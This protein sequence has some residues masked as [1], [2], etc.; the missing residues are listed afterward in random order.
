MSALNNN[1]KYTVYA[2]YIGYIVQGIINNIS[3]IFFVIYQK[4]LGI[5]LDKIGILIALN[6]GTQ[7][8]TD[9]IAAKYVDR[10]GY[11]KSM[12]IA[13]ISA[14]IGIF[15]IGL[16]PLV[17]SNAFLGLVFATILNSIVEDFWRF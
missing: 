8:L 11:R 4:R 15:G 12:I 17:F 10:I 2:C 7:I 14:T 5:S 13:H 9:I 16:F 6:F 3:P 1:Y